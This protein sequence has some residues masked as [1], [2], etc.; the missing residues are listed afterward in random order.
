MTQSTNSLTSRRDFI[1][2][3]GTLAAVSTLAG[4]ALPSVHAAGKEEIR[5]VLVGCGGRGTG[6]AANALS[7]ADR[8][9]I[10]LVAMADAF[11]DRLAGSFDTLNKQ[12]ADKMDVPEER[13]FVGLDGYKKA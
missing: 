9:P 5:V 3:T 13:K 4:L 10:K 12:F 2:T 11:Q 1:K 8:G 7:V 6:A